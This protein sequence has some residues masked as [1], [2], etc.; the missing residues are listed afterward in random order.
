MKIITKFLVKEKRLAGTA[1][2]RRFKMENFTIVLWMQIQQLQ[3]R[4]DNTTL[5]PGF[6][7]FPNITN[8]VDHMNLPYGH[9]LVKEYLLNMIHNKRDK[10]L[11]PYLISSNE[12][13]NYL[14][15]RV[16]GLIKDIKEDI[17]AGRITI[18]HPT[19]FRSPLTRTH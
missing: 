3:T 11:D 4:I 7:Q 14:H 5:I 2:A 9:N 18:K 16:K 19:N 10:L 8:A 12:K 1:T 17:Q 13:S 15:N 6:S